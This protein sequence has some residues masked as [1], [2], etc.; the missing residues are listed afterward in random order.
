MTDTWQQRV[1]RLWSSF[2]PDEAGPFVSAMTALAA[3]KPGDPI[4]LF[5]L[6]GAHDATDSTREAIRLYREALEAGLTEPQARQAT[7]QLAS[8]LRVAGRADEA[9]DLLEQ[10]LRERSDDLDDAVRAFLALALH[11]LG[12]SD[13][14]VG[15]LLTTVAGH[16]SQYARSVRHYADAVVRRS[17]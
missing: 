10:E 2:D 4:A 3:E 11:D 6:G 7:I 16:L 17:R 9:A 15:L 1:D 12:R 14:A 8:S 13:E 5:E